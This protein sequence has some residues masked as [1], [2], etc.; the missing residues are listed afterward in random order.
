MRL[1]F[2][3]GA[4]KHDDLLIERDDV[5]PRSIACPKQGIIPH[6]MVHYAV[7]SV[8]AHR[9]F[10]TMVAD[11]QD[12]DF[13][14]DGAGDSEESVERLV[15]T[16]QAEMWGGRVPVADFLTTYE[17][18]CDARGHTA[19]PVSA[20]DIAAIREQLGMLAVQWA[21]VPVGGALMLDL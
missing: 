6:D 20:D 3:K 4:G 21:G 19:M 13:T 11:G 7:E 8:I 12:A 14:M 18:A 1:V 10:W 17:H 15:E 9:G 2:T 16:F 5:P